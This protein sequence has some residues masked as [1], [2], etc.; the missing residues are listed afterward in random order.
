[1]TFQSYKLKKTTAR[2]IFHA[3]VLYLQYYICLLRSKNKVQV[4][5]SE[6]EVKEI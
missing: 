3:F 1:M 2:A 6:N 5:L 4:F